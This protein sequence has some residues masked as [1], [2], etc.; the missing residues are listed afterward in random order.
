MGFYFWSAK[1]VSYVPQ[2][3][4]IATIN[5]TCLHPTVCGEFMLCVNVCV[6]KPCLQIYIASLR[7]VSPDFVVSSATNLKCVV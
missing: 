7:V 4:T 6:L 2:N 1:H 5:A 3:I